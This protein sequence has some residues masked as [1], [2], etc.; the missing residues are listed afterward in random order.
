MARRARCA[1]V[2]ARAVRRDGFVDVRINYGQVSES[3]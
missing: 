1:L 2:K 3:H